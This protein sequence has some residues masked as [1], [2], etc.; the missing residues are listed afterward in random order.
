MPIDCLP[1]WFD[2][3]G[4]DMRFQRK[5]ERCRLQKMQAFGQVQARLKG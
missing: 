2:P 5:P 1:E 3:L 4:V